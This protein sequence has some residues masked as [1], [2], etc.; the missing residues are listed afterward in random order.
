MV[1]EYSY[2]S[3]YSWLCYYRVSVTTQ[4]SK[5]SD[6]NSNYSL[7]YLLLLLSPT[8]VGGSVYLIIDM[9]SHQL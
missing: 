3:C 9:A 2:Y 7:F 4:L 8:L 6:L 1:D 5:E